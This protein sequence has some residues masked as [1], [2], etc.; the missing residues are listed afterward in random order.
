[1]ELKNGG[2]DSKSI[3]NRAY[4]YAKLKMYDEAVNDYTKALSLDTN[5]IHAMHN[6]GLCY[7]RLGLYRNAIEDFTKVI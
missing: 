6:R 4:C 5:N 7:E 1:M 2:D 3:N